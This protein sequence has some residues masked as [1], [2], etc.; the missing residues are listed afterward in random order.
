M[1]LIYGESFRIMQE[2]IAKI[3]KDEKNVVVFDLAVNT[4]QDVLTEAMYVSLFLE[5]KY[6]IVKNASFFTNS[7]KAKEE[8][9]ELLLHYMKSPVVN[10]IIVFTT[11]DKIDSRKKITKAF[12]EKYK[13]IC[14]NMVQVNDIVN[15]LRDVVIHHNYKVDIE[16]LQYIVQICQNN[17]D[18]AYNELEK[19]F[20][21]YERPQTI[22]LEDVKN[23]V[24]RTISDN[25][26]KFVEAVV[27]KNRKHALR[28]LEDLY[29]LKV[30]P[31]QLFV[32]LAREYRL[33]FS[34]SSFMR[35]GYSKNQLKN[36]LCLQDWQIEK[37][38]RNGSLYYEDDIKEYLKKLA[39]IDYKIK[40][41][42][43]DRFSAMK[44]FLLEIE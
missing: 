6:I 35:R 16:T 19:I 37:L 22:L 21:Y 11:Y 32:L 10:S 28:L 15:K 39:F 14:V 44:L 38:S 24:S 36:E 42:E 5:K 18:L 27:S 4:I 31:I 9:I 7:S 41:G 26:F 17:Y 3:I 25:N 43:M 2:E 8:E 30:D 12:S 23:I 34:L 20:L 29:T 33:L 40:S 13:V 1:Y